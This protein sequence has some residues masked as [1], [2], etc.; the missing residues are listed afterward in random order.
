MQGGRG[1]TM[2]CKDTSR[3][4][5]HSK[6]PECLDQADAIQLYSDKKIKSHLYNYIGVFTMSG[7]KGGLLLLVKPTRDLTLIMCGIRGD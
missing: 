3:W 6:S 5:R 4:M 2:I 7:E 1:F